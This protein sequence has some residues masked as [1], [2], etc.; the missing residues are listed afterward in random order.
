MKSAIVLAAGVLVAG[1]LLASPVSAATLLNFTNAPVEN[2]DYTLKFTATATTTSL[3]VGGYQVLNDEYVSN[4]IVS[5]G[6]GPNLLGDDWV[7][8]PAAEGSF[9][10]TYANPD[11]GVSTVPALNIGAETPGDYDVF[12]QTF[13][14]VIG[15]IYSYTFNFVEGHT[16]PSGFE[17]TTTASAATPE[18][19]TWAMIAVGLGGLGAIMRRRRSDVA[20]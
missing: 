6:E 20:L 8:T 1:G 2:I 15:D 9:S 16:G 14:T 19:A 7:F 18:P 13:A 10:Y 17:V 3:S 12:T 11:L 5:T 4:N